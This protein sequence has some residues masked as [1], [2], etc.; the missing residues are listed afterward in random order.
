MNNLLLEQAET[1]SDAIL[2]AT[3]SPDRNEAERK[4]FDFLTR[5][6]P[7]GGPNNPGSRTRWHLG[8]SA[9]DG[10]FPGYTLSLAWTT[11]GVVTNAVIYVS[12]TG[13]LTGTSVS[14]R[15]I[16]LNEALKRKGESD[17]DGEK[18]ELA[19]EV[20]WSLPAGQRL[21][22][23]EKALT[24]SGYHV[25]P[26]RSEV[27]ALLDVADG[28]SAGYLGRVADPATRLA[29]SLLISEEHGQ[30]SDWSGGYPNLGDDSLVAGS[31]FTHYR[32]VA[33]LLAAAHRAAAPATN[34]QE[35]SRHA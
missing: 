25:V 9:L 35:V 26:A 7:E 29:A 20:T 28:R 11:A 33:R 14:S 31:H 18:R 3:T 24:A 1:G 32:R 23:V 10:T 19:Q 21:H 17:W 12:T 15:A 30:V 4:A 13:A 16:P 27:L 2:S 34:P 22:T 5:V 8:S 6:C